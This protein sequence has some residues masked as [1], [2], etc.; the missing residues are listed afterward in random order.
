MMN[1]DL[2][3]LLLTRSPDAQVFLMTTRKQPF[4]KQLLGVVGRD[5]MADQ[6][7]RNDPGIETNDVFLVTGKRI[8]PGSLSAWILTE[9]AVAAPAQPDHVEWLGPVLDSVAHCETQAVEEDDPETY[10]TLSSAELREALEAAHRA[11]QAAN[12]QTAHAHLNEA[13]GA[14]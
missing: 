9:R 6:Q 7:G 4:E 12:H 5:E 2:I 8:R 3:K 10:F 14:D 11:G 13:T 1:K